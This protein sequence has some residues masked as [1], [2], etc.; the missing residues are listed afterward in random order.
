MGSKKSQSTST[1]LPDYIT[2]GSE[3]AVGRGMEALNRPYTPYE[4]ERVAGLSENEAMASQMARDTAGVGMGYLSQGADALGGITSFDQ[5]NIGAY[6]NP[7]IEQV[8]N[9][10]QEALGEAYGGRKSELGQKAG[11]VSAFGGGR[12]TALETGLEEEYLDSTA[13]MQEAGL[14]SAFDRATGLWGS[15]MDRLIAQSGAYGGLA[16]QAGASASSDIRNLAGTGLTERSIDQAQKDFDYQQFIESRDWD[17][18]NL[19]PLLEALSMAPYET[20]T[21]SETEGSKLG[22]AVGLA[23][24]IGGFLAGGG[25]GGLSSMAPE[26]MGAG[27]S[28]LGGG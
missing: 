6:M 24:T 22:T 25:I 15:D 27:L 9:R 14:A 11:M 3:A 7:Y 12:Q 28:T 10:Q 26:I 16:G 23:S 1:E 8:L 19:G 2:S 18:N 4:D 20:T 5:A 17:I 21:T 13:A